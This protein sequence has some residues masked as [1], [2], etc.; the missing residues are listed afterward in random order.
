MSA[1]DRL[2]DT[3][4]RLFEDAIELIRELDDTEFLCPTLTPGGGGIG[5][6]LRHCADFARSLLDG[7]LAGRIDYDARKRD[8]LFETSRGHA[9]G[10]LESLAERL[11]ALDRVRGERALAVKTEAA[12]LPRGVDP[13]CDSSLR[14]ELLALLSHTVHHFA[15]VRERLRA[16]GC[17]PGRD[18]GLAPSTRAHESGTCAR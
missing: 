7:L 5:P 16:R 14:R 13:W 3:N 15:L 6:Q 9:L 1:T 10:E 4:A 2:G 18:F 17:D 12:A 8:P 11:R